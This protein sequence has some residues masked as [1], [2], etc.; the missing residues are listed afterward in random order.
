MSQQ[1]LIKRVKQHAKQHDNFGRHGVKV[2]R[3]K[4]AQKAADL[5]ALLAEHR[6]VK[7]ELSACKRALCSV[8][9]TGFK[10]NGILRKAGVKL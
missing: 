7:R 3:D 5:R 1:A 9:Y 10:A 4:H 8:F 2:L 6:E